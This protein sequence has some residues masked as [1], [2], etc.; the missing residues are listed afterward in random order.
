MSLAVVDITSQSKDDLIQIGDEVVF[1]GRQGNYEITLRE[2]ANKIGKSITEVLMQLGSQS[3]QI[4]N[5]DLQCC[6]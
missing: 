3:H 2:F 6:H 1:I 4:I 5:Q